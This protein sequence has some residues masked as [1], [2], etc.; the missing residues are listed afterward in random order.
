MAFAST[1]A[2]NFLPNCYIPDPL[3]PDTEN[4]VNISVGTF[5]AINTLLDGYYANFYSSYNT[6]YNGYTSLLS[7]LET[8]HDSRVVFRKGHRGK[9]YWPNANHHGLISNEDYTVSVPD[10][11]IYN[12]TSSANIVTF[13]WH[14][15]TSLN[16]PEGIS[17]DG[18]GPYGMPY[19]WTHND[20]MHEYDDSGTQVFLGWTNEV[21]EPEYPAPPYPEPDGG[22]PQYEYNITATYNYAFVAYY[23]WYFMCEDY[24]VGDSLDSL[25]DIIYDE[26]FVATDLNGWLKVWGNMDLDLP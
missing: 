13:I 10:D 16:Y 9:P 20:D 1:G 17:G 26:D 25:C 19:C 23:F 15:E 4:E 6:T 2:A 14:C 11:V 7:T 24:S 21:P 18:I 3:G 5:N 22:S 12:Y 8:Y